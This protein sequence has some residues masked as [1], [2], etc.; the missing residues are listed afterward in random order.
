MDE[1]SGILRKI[2]INRDNRAVDR[3]NEK[4]EHEFFCLIEAKFWCPVICT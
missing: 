1:V 4:R 3:K 2:K